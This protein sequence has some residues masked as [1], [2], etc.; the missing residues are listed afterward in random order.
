M[1]SW[2]ALDL[3]RWNVNLSSSFEG[4]AQ[5]KIVTMYIRYND[6]TLVGTAIN[7]T[8]FFLKWLVFWSSA[9]HLFA[10]FGKSTA[11]SFRCGASQLL[12]PLY[13]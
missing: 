3:C 4:G 8:Y 5:R 13:I 1:F 2:H 6:A 11:N 10:V 7:Q 9:M 12:L